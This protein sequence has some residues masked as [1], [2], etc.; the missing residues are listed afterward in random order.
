[1]IQLAFCDDDHSILDRIDTLFEQYRIDRNVEMTCSLFHSPL[2]LLAK[3]EKG[4][5][6]DILFLDVLMPGENGINTAKEI[7]QYDENV[8]I[9]FLTSSSDFAV[10]SYSVGAYFYQLKPLSQESFFKLMDSCIDECKKTQ[11]RILI[12]N[13]QKGVVRIDLEKLKYCEV[14]GRTLLFYMENGKVLECN[15]NLNELCN[16]LA[17][18]DEFF[19]PHRSYLVNMTHIQN[20]S[21]REITMD[22]HTEIPIPHGKSKDVKAVYLEYAFKRKQLLI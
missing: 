9:I 17:E 5:R 8:K 2:E 7:R 11:G 10:Q 14:S 22:D 12:M 3:I 21:P 18:Y 6:F 19:R 16:G 4:M 20:I 1:M 13:S 15:G